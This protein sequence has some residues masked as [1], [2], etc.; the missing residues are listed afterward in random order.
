[1]K[2]MLDEIF[3]LLPHEADED[4][5]LLLWALGRCP[6]KDEPF[7]IIEAYG[8]GEDAVDLFVLDRAQNEKQIL[9]LHYKLDQDDHN[10]ALTLVS[11]SSASS[12]RELIS[13]LELVL[14]NEQSYVDQLRI[15]LRAFRRSEKT[16]NRAHSGRP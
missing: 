4:D 16:S 12:A 1:M 11:A 5:G 2:A 14:T 13:A 3:I 7:E 10:G 8:Q 9:H 15:G 6:M